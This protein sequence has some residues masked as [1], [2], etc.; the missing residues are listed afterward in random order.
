MEVVEKPEGLPSHL[1]KMLNEHKASASFSASLG[2]EGGSL[3]LR[4]FALTRVIERL[5]AEREE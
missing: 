5:G 2:V 3:S 1:H 4:F